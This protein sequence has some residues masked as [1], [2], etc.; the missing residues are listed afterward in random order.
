MTLMCFS[1]LLLSC[2]HFMCLVTLRCLVTVSKG[3][4]GLVKDFRFPSKSNE[5]LLEL[6]RKEFSTF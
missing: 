4:S 2:Y 3:R 5:E 6:G 1:K